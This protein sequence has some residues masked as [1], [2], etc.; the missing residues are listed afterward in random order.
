[1]GADETKTGRSD[2]RP[3]HADFKPYIYE[4]L[5]TW[6]PLFLSPHDALWAS[7]KGGSLAYTYVGSIIS[8]TT[9]RELGIVVNPHLFRDCAVFTIAHNAGERMGIASALLQHTDARV[10]NAHYN[11]GSSVMAV[12]EFHQV[13]RALK[14]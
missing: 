2:E 8:E 6:R 10:T 5:N 7:T 3:L 1:L 14:E 12:Q 11:R 4:W 9:R 13:L